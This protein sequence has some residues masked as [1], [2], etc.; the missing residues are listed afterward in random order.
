MSRVKYERVERA[1]LVNAYGEIRFTSSKVIN[2][3]SLDYKKLLAIVSKASPFDTFI[4][5][6]RGVFDDF[7]DCRSKFQSM[8]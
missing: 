2:I 4:V 6:N 1:F 7:F 5:T 3:M 8:A